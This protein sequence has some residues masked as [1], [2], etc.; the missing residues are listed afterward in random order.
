MCCVA[1]LLQVITKRDGGET[2]KRTAKLRD[3]SGSVELVL[4]GDHAHD[5]GDQL[6]AQMQ[7]S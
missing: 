7:V 4:W 1:H 6:E 3:R 5:P 2:H